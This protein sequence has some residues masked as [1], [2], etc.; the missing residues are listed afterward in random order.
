MRTNYSVTENREAPVCRNV[1]KCC[2]KMNFVW[3]YTRVICLLNSGG[4][5]VTPA[6]SY[7]SVDEP[8]LHHERPDPPYYMLPPVCPTHSQPAPA[9]SSTLPSHPASLN[10]TAGIH[11][12]VDIIDPMPFH[13]LHGRSVILS[14]DRMVARRAPDNYCNG[15]VFTCRAL[16]LGERFVTSVTAVEQDY[17]GGLAFGMTSC[18][19]NCLHAI[20]LPDDAD[21]LLDRP[22]YWVVHKDI[23]A[24]PDVGDELSFSLTSSGT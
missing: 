1:L 9:L 21:L 5:Q 16:H 15:Y 22:E 12:H 11:P 24:K 10:L 4:E 19:P 14:L 18:D 2:L 3:F 23:C 13:Y 17:V 6:G 7:I 20:D 8:V